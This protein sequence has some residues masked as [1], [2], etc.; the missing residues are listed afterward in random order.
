LIQLRRE[1]AALAA[2][3]KNS[4]EVAALDDRFIIHIRRWHNES[5]VFCVMSFNKD[6]TSFEAGLPP[7]KWRKL[8]DSSEERWGGPGSDLPEE[9]AR[10]QELNLRPFSFA[11]YERTG[12]E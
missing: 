11:L 10:E 5:H 9:I 8:I 12:S 6:E 3:D 1:T 4:F 7:G 2:L